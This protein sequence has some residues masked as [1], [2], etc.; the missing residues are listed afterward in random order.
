[1]PER[2]WSRWKP[3][4]SATP[5]CPSSTA[6][7]LVP[8]PCCSATRRAVA[9]TELGRGRDGPSG[10]PTRRHDVPPPLRRVRR[11]RH[12][13]PDAV[14]PG[15]RE[16][17]RR[18]DA[19]RRYAAQPRRATRSTTIS[20][21]PRSPRTRSWTPGRWSPWTTTS[22]R[23]WRRS[24]GV[25]CSPAAG[26][27]ST[28]RH[29]SPVRA[30]W[31]S[32]WAGSAWPSAFT[33]IALG[34]G[35]VVVVDG[36]EAKRN[37]ARE[38][39]ATMALDP[40]ELESRGVKADVVVEAAGNAARLRGRAGGHAPGRPHGHGRSSQRGGASERVTAAARRGGA[41]R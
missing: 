39:G 10:G 9:S 3:P 34:A 26:P 19:R 7:D 36:V 16:Q 1:M 2:Y 32:G 22:P 27:S 5:T 17:Q 12:R 13:R 29:P 41:G 24:S 33:A 38:L 11:L 25:P 4:G 8:S 6:T 31:S 40:A 37:Q 14:R 30:S 23:R 18:R 21:C 35:D 20:A 15:I 28:P